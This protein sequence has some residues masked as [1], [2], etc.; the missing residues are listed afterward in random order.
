MEDGS[1]TVK[2]L[3]GLPMHRR[4]AEGASC[5]QQLCPHQ[6]D[7]SARTEGTSYPKEGNVRSNKLRLTTKESL[8]LQPFKFPAKGS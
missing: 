7:G 5:K 2:R 4:T 3:V 8:A 6:P 1:S